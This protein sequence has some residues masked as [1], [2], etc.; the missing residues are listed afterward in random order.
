[1]HQDILT[2]YRTRRQTCQVCKPATQ[3]QPWAIFIG[4]ARAI[5]AGPAGIHLADNLVD[6]RDW[7]LAHRPSSITYHQEPK[8]FLK[9]A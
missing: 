1:M 5:A 4:K 3:H 8:G 6:A 7:V 9:T 2:A